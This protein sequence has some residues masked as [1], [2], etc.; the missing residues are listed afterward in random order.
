MKIS[1][2]INYSMD[3]CWNGQG[4]MVFGNV[5]CF[6][7]CEYKKYQFTKFPSNFISGTICSIYY[8]EIMHDPSEI[9]V[10]VIKINK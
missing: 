10:K 5:M 1:K 6:Y 2:L 7:S 9:D 8:H 3:M 4:T